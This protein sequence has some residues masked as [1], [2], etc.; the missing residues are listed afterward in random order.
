MIIIIGKSS[1]NRVNYINAFN[2]YTV[3]VTQGYCTERSFE[4]KATLT[5]SFDED[6]PED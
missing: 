6:I 5:D 4:K 2:Y 3:T 1:I